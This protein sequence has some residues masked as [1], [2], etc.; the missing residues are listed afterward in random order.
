MIESKQRRWYCP[1]ERFDFLEMFPEEFTLQRDKLTILKDRPL[2]SG[3]SSL[4]TTGELL[5]NKEGV[6]KVAV[7]TSSSNSSYRQIK[8]FLME[9]VIL[10]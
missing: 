9:A 7:K 10:Q 1:T 8:Q 4:V 5:T 2:G 3:N 6:K